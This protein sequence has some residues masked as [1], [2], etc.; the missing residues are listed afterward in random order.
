M[1]GA[2][3]DDGAEEDLKRMSAE[4]PASAPAT[5]RSARGSTR[6]G[7][8]SAQECNSI[9][10]RCRALLYP[11]L[12]DPC[13]AAVL[14]GPGSVL[15]LADALLAQLP[16]ECTS[17]SPIVSASSCVQRHEDLIRWRC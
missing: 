17:H 11:L 2:A 1:V 14:E 6:S 16:L 9:V 12:S 3:T 7:D 13:I 5:G 10:A 8:P 15:L 4:A